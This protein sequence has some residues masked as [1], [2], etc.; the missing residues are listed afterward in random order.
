MVVPAQ[1]LPHF[2]I[3]VDE[4]ANEFAQGW[5]Y[6]CYSVPEFMFISVTN[7]WHKKNLQIIAYLYKRKVYGRPVLMQPGNFQFQHPV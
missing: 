7:K 5:L 2:F 4:Q 1:F 3:F 6:K